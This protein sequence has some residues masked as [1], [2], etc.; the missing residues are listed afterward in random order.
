[1]HGIAIRKIAVYFA[2]DLSDKGI[3]FVGIYTIVRNEKRLYLSFFHPIRCAYTIAYRVFDPLS[4]IGDN[5]QNRHIGC[6]YTRIFTVPPFFK[7]EIDFVFHCKYVI[8]VSE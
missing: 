2:F 5:C 3:Y 1:M 4:G 7:C 6:V 8:Y